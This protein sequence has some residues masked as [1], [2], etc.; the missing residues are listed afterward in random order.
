MFITEKTNTTYFLYPILGFT[1]EDE[2]KMGF[3]SSF[4]DDKNR[5]YIDDGSTRVYCLFKPLSH[6]FFYFNYKVAE[7]EKS[8]ILE[9]EYEYPGG[10]TV[11]VFK[12]PSKYN[13]DYELFRQSKFSKFSNEFK[14]LFPQKKIEFKNTVK[15][16]SYS[17][18][19]HVFN[20]TPGIRRFMEEKTGVSMENFDKDFEF[21]N[22]FNSEVET[23]DIKNFIK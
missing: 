16:E 11:L 22:I 12:L 6:L 17:L 2:A 13:R 3:V 18:Q 7:F 10:Y 19:F 9:D 23:L 8:G 1:D 4:S 20:K 15:H 5:S 21:W 14:Q